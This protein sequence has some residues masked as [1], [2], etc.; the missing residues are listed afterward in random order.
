ML[1]LVSSP[2]VL[3]DGVPKG[4]AIFSAHCAICHGVNADGRG[5]LANDLPLRPRNFKG[6]PLQWGNTTRSMV[7]TVKV[8]R[9]NVM[10]SFAEV[11]TDA[12]IRAVVDYVYGLIPAKLKNQPV[13]AIHPSPSRKVWVVHQAGKRF[14]PNSISAQVDDVLI[15]INEDD[16]VHEVHDV[17]QHLGPPIHSQEIG[18]WDRLVLNEPGTIRFGCAIHP[19]MALTVVVGGKKP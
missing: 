5:E 7:Q 2:A 12:E 6:E 18:Q 14:T 13:T 16:V 15:F 4:A 3:A 8:G 9:S 19:A 17:A 11:L 1:A 10:P